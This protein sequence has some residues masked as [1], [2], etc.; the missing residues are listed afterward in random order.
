MEF[1]SYNLCFLDEELQKGSLHD[2]QLEQV[3]LSDKELSHQQWQ[4]VSW[5][6]V[7]YSDNNLTQLSW[8]T[9]EVKESDFLDLQSTQLHWDNVKLSGVRFL[10]NHWNHP[11]F[12]RC[13]VD[14]SIN[15]R[16]LVQEGRFD[17]CRFKDTEFNRASLNQTLFKE[18]RFE[19]SYGEGLLG[20]HKSDFSNCLFWGCYFAGDFGSD[21]EWNN[22]LFVN[23]HFDRV[24][25]ECFQEGSYF[26]KDCINSPSSYNGSLKHENYDSSQLDELYKRIED[27]PMDKESIAGMLEDYSQDML[28][29][30]LADLLSRKPNV[31]QQQSTSAQ[32]EWD[33][34]NNF[35]HLMRYIK[36]KYD[37][38]ELD[39]FNV[40]GNAVHYRHKGRLHLISE[41]EE[42]QVTEPSSPLEESSS[43]RF[44]KLEL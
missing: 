3:D 13:D 11:H 44:G 8:I 28:R 38:A 31:T 15:H 26:F 43:G 25:V 41:T 24:G 40:E 2:T 20:F 22:C 39:S 21:I 36:Q 32:T 34:I 35:T 29:D 23:C 27:Q 17:S 42:P 12:S 37:F 19:T 7:R 9:G 30:T 10:R 4:E 14:R 33:K 18:C 1:N 6:G 5:A 16:W